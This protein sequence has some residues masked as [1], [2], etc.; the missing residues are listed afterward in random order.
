MIWNAVVSGG[1]KTR[2]KRS[3]G[4]LQAVSPLQ[5]VSSWA[6]VTTTVQWYKVTVLG[7]EKD[8]GICCTTQSVQITQS[9]LTLW[10]PMDCSMPGL[11]VHHQLPEF[12]QTNVHWVSDTI[13]P[14]HSLSSRSP[15]AFNLSQHQGLFQWVS[16]SHQVD[17]GLELQLQCLHSAYS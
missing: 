9:C 11:P 7:D 12:T 2:K 3:S 8:L 10:D 5:A 13:Q 4:V 16:S 15:P 6:A 14:T 17:K 1:T